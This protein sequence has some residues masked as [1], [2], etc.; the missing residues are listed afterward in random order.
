MLDSYDVMD[1]TISVC[2]TILRGHRFIF[3]DVMLR[4]VCGGYVSH[5]RGFFVS[6]T[7]FV[8]FLVGG[9]F[10]FYLPPSSLFPFS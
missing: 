2:V 1:L 4:R 5:V 6:P 8:L 7:F 3:G 10:N 9:F